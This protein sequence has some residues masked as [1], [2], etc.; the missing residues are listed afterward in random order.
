MGG[1]GNR[2][3]NFHPKGLIMLFLHQIRLKMDQ[4]GPKMDPKGLIIDK[5]AKN[6]V[7]GPKIPILCQTWRVPPT[8]VYNIFGLWSGPRGMPLPPYVQTTSL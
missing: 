1:S 8:F 2:E 7:F 4:I 5:W 3:E 6:S